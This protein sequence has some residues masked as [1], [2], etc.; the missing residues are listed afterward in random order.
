[1]TGPTPGPEGIVDD[2]LSAEAVVVLEPL[3]AAEEPDGQ[4]VLDFVAALRKQELELAD[5]A[6]VAEADATEAIAA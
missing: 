6:E 4:V 3:E 2:T 1:M 5:Q